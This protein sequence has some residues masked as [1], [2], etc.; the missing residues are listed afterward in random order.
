[1]EHLEMAKERL[2]LFGIVGITEEYNG[3]LEL[4]KD[5]LGWHYDLAQQRR[6]SHWQSKAELELAD[7][8]ETLNKLRSL[9]QLDLLLYN[10]AKKLYFDQRRLYLNGFLRLF[11]AGL[12]LLLYI[13]TVGD[14]ICP[15]KRKRWKEV[16]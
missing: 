7:N 14:I 1:M 5:R 10:Y 4:L 3:F 15:C 12:A 9:N 8:P 13:P 16:G 11:S 2:A 6:N